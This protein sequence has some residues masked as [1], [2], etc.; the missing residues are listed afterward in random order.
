MNKDH[1]E[2]YILYGASFNPP[3]IGHFS[4]ISQ[5]LEEHDKVIVFPYPKKF[6]NGNYESLPPI[7][8]R[9]KMLQIFALN[10]FPQMSERLIIVNLAKLIEKENVED[11]ILHTYDYLN[12]VKTQI[13][14]NAKLKVCLGFDSQKRDGDKEVLLGDVKLFVDAKSLFYLMG[15]ELDFTDGLNGRGFTFNNPNAAKTCGCGSSFGV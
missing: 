7:N 8:Q 13:P 5:M 11:Q 2:T 4:A 1:S 3:H 10:F 15:T 12:F 6:V 9:M 14:E